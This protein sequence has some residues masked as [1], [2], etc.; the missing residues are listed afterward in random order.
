M[1]F[2]ET[3]DES[4]TH[5]AIAAVLCRKVCTQ[6]VGLLLG[7]S[8][9]RWINIDATKVNRQVVSVDAGVEVCRA[10]PVLEYGWASV[11]DD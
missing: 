3:S 2:L 7:H 9:T 5:I 10:G 1:A 11:V 4:V 6:N 8:Q